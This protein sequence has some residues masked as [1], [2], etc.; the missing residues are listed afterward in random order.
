MTATDRSDEP[1]TP[2]EEDGAIR[3]EYDWTVTTPSTA[4]V[5][6]VAIASNRK[7]TG[8]EPLYE[9]IDPDALNA[10]IRSNGAESVDDGTVV[11][12]EFV[13]QSVTVHGGGVVVVRSVERG[14]GDT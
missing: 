4:V 7:S 1:D 14:P 10:L 13:G 6:T 12:F 2:S 5:E 8:I 9:F 3:A 11:T